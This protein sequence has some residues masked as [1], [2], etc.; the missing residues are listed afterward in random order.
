MG[1]QDNRT[2]EAVN[3]VV[4]V[5]PGCRPV[6]RALSVSLARRDTSP[7]R[8]VQL[9]E[10]QSRWLVALSAVLAIFVLG[11]LYLEPPPAD[12]GE[13]RRWTRIAGDR[14]I[15]TAS[16]VEVRV[17]GR[18]VRM[19]RTEG[20]WRWVEP[21]AVNGDGARVDALLQSVLDVE[22]GD[23][24]EVRPAD[25]G[26]DSEA[27]EVQVRFQ[28]AT[29]LK[30]AVGDD[31]AVGSSTYVRDASGAVRATRTRLTTALPASVDELRSR[32]IASFPRSDVRRNALS[33]RGEGPFPLSVGVTTGGL[34]TGVPRSA[35]PRPGSTP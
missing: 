19:E 17:A 23:V 18:T 16:E 4:A 33:A 26:I 35:R 24:I 34:P 29:S 11:I 9:D 7:G 10:R 5:R 20:V 6:A 32:A 1:R 28:D 15:E 2:E 12:P 27:I 3:R 25:V 21:L 31:A 30:L 14:S 22:L 13:G 8:K